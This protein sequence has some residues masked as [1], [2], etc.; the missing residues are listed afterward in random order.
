MG[1]GTAFIT[2]SRTKILTQSQVKI[3]EYT[4][5]RTA[6]NKN[7]TWIGAIV[8]TYTVEEKDWNLFVD[9]YAIGDQVN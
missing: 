6:F 2:Y 8:L 4:C 7:N 5:E 9:P 3:W 1:N